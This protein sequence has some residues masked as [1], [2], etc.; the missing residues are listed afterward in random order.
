MYV[1]SGLPKPSTDVTLRSVVVALMAFF[2]TDI[3]HWLTPAANR[4]RALKGGWAIPIAIIFVLV[5]PR[6]V[7][8]MEGAD[9]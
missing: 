8:R 3:I 6:A 7:L 5:C 4:F 1:A 2:H 9:G